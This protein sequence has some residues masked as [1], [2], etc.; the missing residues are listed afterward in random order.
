MTAQITLGDKAML[1]A[2]ILGEMARCV[3]FQLNTDSLEAEEQYAELENYLKEL[4][5]KISC[6]ECK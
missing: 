5:I 3:V 4:N 2:L 6:L 1:H